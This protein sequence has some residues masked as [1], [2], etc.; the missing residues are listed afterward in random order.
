MTIG[1]KL[2]L[3]IQKVFSTEDL[4]KWEATSALAFWSD[5]GLKAEPRWPLVKL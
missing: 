1:A 5:F 2:V 4:E 3:T